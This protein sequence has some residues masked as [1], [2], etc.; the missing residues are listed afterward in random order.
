MT[1]STLPNFHALNV[2]DAPPER[3][4]DVLAVIRRSFGA[5]PVLDPPSTALTE[6]VESVREAL[7]EGGGLLVERRGKPIGA[8]LYDTSRP[9]LLGFRRVSVDPDHQDRGVASAMVGVAED[10]AE[11][12]GLD[13]VW[14]DVREELPENV[15]FWTRRRYFP[16]RQHGT[17]IEFGKT[18]WLARELPTAEDAHAFGVR[19]ASLLQAGD[20]VVMSGGL[21]AGK[22]T[23]TQGIGEGLGVRGP[24]T[25]PT[26][27]L[28]RTHPNLAGGPPLVHVDA[29][30]LGGAL[31]LD[32]L[33]LDTATEDSVTVVEWGAGMAEDLSD[34]WLEVRLERRAATVLDP[35]GAEAPERADVDDHD[36]RLVTVK[37]HGVR[38]ARVPLRST[39]LGPGAVA[40]SAQARGL[41]EPRPL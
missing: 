17:T 31:E 21:G 20:V 16:V 39:L 9:G 27:V 4:A 30:R 38:W 14:L 32:D 19:L 24:V 2:F 33:D 41:E 29:Y 18:L 8:M 10:T 13:G 6:S 34:S 25:S 36:V 1:G 15:T 37:P 28:A 11:E 12:R 7:A 26:F 3:A 23:L 22:T 35:L 5:R 40:H